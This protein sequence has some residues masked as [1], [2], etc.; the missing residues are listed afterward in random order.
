MTKF[1]KFS[2]FICV[3][4]I[5]PLVL[6]LVAIVAAGGI[7]FF[8]GAEIMWLISACFILSAITAVWA[9][10]FLVVITVNKIIEWREDRQWRKERPDEAAYD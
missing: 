6:T 3:G 10:L 8:T 4:L 5:Y 1:E 9:V 2:E 7:F